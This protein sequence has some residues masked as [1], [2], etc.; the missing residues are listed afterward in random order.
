MSA[1]I[2]AI[3]A[4]EQETKLLRMAAYARTS[5]DSTDQLNSYAAQI[6][7]YTEYINGNPGWTLVDI[8]A[9]QGLTGTGA[10][11]RDEFQ[12]M[13]ADCRRG[14][15]DRILVK[16]VSRF[17]RNISDCLS[18]I[19][20]LKGL[21]VTV[22]FEEEKL[23]T[24]DMSSEFLL[25]MQSMRAQGESQSI[26]RNL[27]WMYQRRMKAGEFIS[28]KAPFG[29]RLLG[30]SSL[31]IVPEE[32]EIVRRM[33]EMF[34][35]GLGRQKICD[36]L[37]AEQAAN[38]TWNIKSLQYILENEKYIG[39]SLVQKNFTTDTLPYKKQLNQGERPQYYIENSHPPIIDRATFEATQRLQQ[40]RKTK[41]QRTQHPLNGKLRCPDCGTT[42]RR[43]VINGKARWTCSKALCGQTPCTPLRLWE[44]AAHETF[45]LLLNKL[46]SHR[47]TI[48]LPL[49]EQTEILQAKANGTQQKIYQIDQKIAALTAQC[50]ALA[51]LH[52]K[53]VLDPAAYSA[54]ISKLNG[55]LTGLRN[56]RRAIL[57]INENDDQL[58]EL[59]ALNDR[60]AGLDFQGDFDADLFRELVQSIVPAQAELRFTLLGGFVLTE[61]IS[62]MERRWKR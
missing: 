54:Q 52:T 28:C 47:E 13:I 36:V 6:R 48:L 12:R 58:N 27:R 53:G 9:D 14:K 22:C 26:S 38:R 49:I 11:K 33:F 37:N 23:D 41:H 25:T 31:E 60:L 3:P 44:S 40:Q 8:Y 4:A 43:Q 18:A 42:F 62:N 46:I 29:Y 35:A 16:S 19:R 32:A 51:R 55:E 61:A 45:L 59:R 50:H 7:H 56:D 10:D 5:S 39:D 17:A 1:T 30:S 34:L 57:H 15:I 20:L 21:G 2:T 24:A